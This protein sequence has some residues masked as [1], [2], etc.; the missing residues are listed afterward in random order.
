MIKNELQFPNESNDGMSNKYKGNT[1]KYYAK[2]CGDDPDPSLQWQI[3]F[4]AEIN[5]M[6]KKADKIT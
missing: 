3:N 5:D 4:L 1:K 6:L 2:L